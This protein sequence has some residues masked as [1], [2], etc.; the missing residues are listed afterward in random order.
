MYRLSHPR[1][2][3][4]VQYRHTRTLLNAKKYRFMNKPAG[5]WNGGRARM[6]LVVEC[7]VG[8]MVFPTSL[9]SK[10]GLHT[11]LNGLFA[12]Q[13]SVPNWHPGPFSACRV[14]AIHHTP[15]G[16]HAETVLCSGPPTTRP[17]PT[18]AAS[19]TYS[20]LQLLLHR[21][22]LGATT[23]MQHLLLLVLGLE[24]RAEED[25]EPDSVELDDG[26]RHARRLAVARLP[27]HMHADCH[28]DACQK[29]QQL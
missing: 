16:S 4:S 27:E 24:E 10:A 12:I 17:A 18:T 8:R 13:G 21:V 23:P 5:H 26:Q 6:A 19:K 15:R 1:L 2:R 28:G 3:C 7:I 11:C 9:K 22:V 14:Q 20:A 29:L 25:D